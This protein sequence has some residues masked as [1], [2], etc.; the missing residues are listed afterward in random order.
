MLHPTLA[1]IMAKLTFLNIAIL[2]L[3]GVCF[4][5]SALAVPHLSEKREPAS[6]PPVTIPA[7]QQVCK[8]S[9]DLYT[10]LVGREYTKAKCTEFENNMKA[11]PAG[12][13][14]LYQNF[15]GRLPVCVRGTNNHVTLLFVTKKKGQQAGVEKVL[16]KT[17]PV[18]NSIQP[19]KCTQL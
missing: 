9:N 13:Q 7:N 17:F 1:L 19:F 5:H 4:A 18:I 14:I 2:A 6:L 3:V 12:V 10:V 8:Y 16:A 15:F 11:A